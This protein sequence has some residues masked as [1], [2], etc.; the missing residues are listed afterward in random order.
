VDSTLGV[1]RSLEARFLGMEEAPSSNLGTSTIKLNH[2]A[3]SQICEINVFS[4]IE[5]S[6]TVQFYSF[7][8]DTK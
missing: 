3:N 2:P 8:I 6:Q 1:W 5:L 4:T 7:C